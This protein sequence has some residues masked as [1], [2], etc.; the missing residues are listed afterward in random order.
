MQIAQEHWLG[1][2]EFS[3]MTWW[4]ARKGG[5]HS[6]EITRDRQ[7]MGFPRVGTYFGTANGPL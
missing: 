4:L 7:F 6:R 3:G 5:N 1:E 2:I